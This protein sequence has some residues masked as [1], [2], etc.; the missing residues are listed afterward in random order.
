[1]KAIIDPKEARRFARFL[2][3]RA[4]DL[5]RLNSDI[6]RTLLDLKLNH[7]KDAKYQQFEKR[8][9]ET[10]IQL[11]H[12]LEQAERYANYLRRKVVPIERFLERRY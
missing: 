6:S 11:Q 5:K 10:S 9:E 3:E 12:F 1:M 2:D 7:W 4:A 8:Y